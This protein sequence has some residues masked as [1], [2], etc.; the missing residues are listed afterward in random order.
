MGHHLVGYFIPKHVQSVHQ[1]C[2]HLSLFCTKLSWLPASVVGLSHESI[3]N[4]KGPV[5]FGDQ[6]TVFLRLVFS[7]GRSHTTRVIVLL[8]TPSLPFCTVPVFK[9]RR[10]KLRTSF[11]QFY[12][13]NFIT[14]SSSNYFGK[15][16]ESPRLKPPENLGCSRLLH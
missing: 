16:H 13:S 6:F 3:C 4:W 9:F 10:N 1:T 7:N 11:R 12:S 2:R 14:P 15:K 8:I 5:K